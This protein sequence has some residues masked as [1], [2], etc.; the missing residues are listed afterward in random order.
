MG[1]T[2]PDVVGSGGERGCWHVCMRFI[3]L[4]TVRG[5]QLSAEGD[6]NIAQTCLL[7]SVSILGVAS[8]FFNKCTQ[9]S[10]SIRRGW[11]WDVYTILRCI[12][13]PSY[14][15]EGLQTNPYIG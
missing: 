13:L 1:H 15:G 3:A 9:L 14:T 5:M 11:S 10:V 4:S 7:L 8:C 6:K 12:L 2:H